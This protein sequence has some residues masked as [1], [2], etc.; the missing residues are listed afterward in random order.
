MDQTPETR[1]TE[2]AALARD[3][4]MPE[5]AAEWI[6]A[7]TTVDHARSE[8]LTALRTHAASRPAMQPAHDTFHASIAARAH[9]APN[10]SPDVAAFMSPESSA[11]RNATAQLSRDM[12]FA[13]RMG[14]NFVPLDVARLNRPSASRVLT[15]TGST[16]GAELVPKLQMN[17]ADRLR[18]DLVAA[19]VGVTF[20]SISGGTAA[21]PV[22]T[23]DPTVVELAE[24]P[25]SG[26]ALSDPALATREAKPKA[27][28]IRT[29][30]SNHI[31]LSSTP[32]AVDVVS[33]IMSRALAGHMDGRIF[34]GP[35]G[36]N[37]PVG[38]FFATGVTTHGLGATGAAISYAGLVAT[39]KALVDA[40]GEADDAVVITTSAVRAKLQETQDFPSAS[41]GRPLWTDGRVMGRRAFSRAWMPT[42]LT[43]ST[44]TNLHGL[45]MYSPRRAGHLV[46]T[47]PAVEI[48]VDRLT[49]ADK[50]LTYI[51]A[52]LYYD[53]VLLHPGAVVRIADINVT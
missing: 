26:A 22:G 3:A 24:N 14:G 20:M 47:W 1:A 53:V 27:A 5:K 50:Q 17:F 42:T 48:T 36:G 30:V 46:V 51:T 21:F 11:A 25:V 15:T 8:V 23:A 19:D 52:A 45:L 38:A 32:E 6:M 28:V 18:E 39:E 43:K 37:G 7:G 31:T 9:A 13:P 12:G 40:R 2:L 41:A 10:D 35:T 49:G 44:G 4:G 16:S 29:A 33:Q 34:A